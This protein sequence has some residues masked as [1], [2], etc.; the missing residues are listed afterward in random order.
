MTLAE[1]N[2]LQKEK[3][4]VLLTTCCGS[5]NW[6]QQMLG[7]MPF[8]D[9]NQLA[10]TAEEIWYN[11]CD[12]ADWRESFLH[13]PKIGDVKSLTEKFASTSHMAGKEQSGLSAATENVI[14]E[15]AKENIDYENKHGFI[16]IVSATG[17]SADEMLQLLQS[18]ISNTTLDESRIAMGEQH[19]ITLLRLQK[20][21]SADWTVLRPGHITT[22]VLDTAIGKP[23]KGIVISLHAANETNSCIASGITNADGR[24]PDLLPPARTLS[25][26]YYKMVF[27]CGKYFKAQQLKAFYPVVEIV[28]EVFDNT[29][30]HIPLLIS[31]FGYSTYRG[32]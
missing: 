24:I 30:Y 21:I 2:L 29:H 16:F 27:Q 14:L 12:Q 8:K 23:G 7:F 32:S 1:F 20:N 17:K 19:K 18:R 6:V 31:P 25:P 9:E 5:S 28:F 10:K 22:H 15:M 11:K 3:A 13:H 4:E 26:G